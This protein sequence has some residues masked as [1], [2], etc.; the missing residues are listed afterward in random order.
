[1]ARFPDVWMS[2][3]YA[4]SDIVD[5]I[6]SYTT[7]TERGGNYWGLCPFHNEKLPS[8]SVN[9]EKQ[10]Y[11]CFGCK[12]GGNVTNFI[13]QTENLS[14]GEAVEFLARRAG[15][16]MP[17]MVD[18]MRFAQIK[19]KKQTIAQMNKK[20]AQFYRDALYSPKGTEALKYLK[21]RGIGE[22][23]IKLFGL[24]YAPDEWDSV[25][26]LLG[27]E[28]FSQSLI[29]ESGLVTVKDNKQYD[30]FRGR[31]MFPIINA[32]GDVIA[33]GGRVLGEAVPKYLNTK[34]TALFNKRFNL[35]G[36]NIL[37]K[38][39]SAR[40]AVIVEG[41]MDVVSMFAHGVKAVVASLGTALTKQQA[42]LLKRYV[43]DCYIAYD[44]DE[45]GEAATKKAI[46]ILET[47]GLSVRV[48]RFEPGQDPDDF[49]K[50]HGLSGFAEKVKA[51]PGSV[52]YKLN[53][54][55]AEHDLST[56][57]GKEA[58]AIEA[59]NILSAIESPITRE[60][61]A[62]QV[63]K[64]TGYSQT[65]VIG[66]MQKKS[67]NKNISTSNRYNNT[68]KGDNTDAQTA[69][70][71]Y[72]MANTRYFEKASEDLTAE[73]F[74]T[75]PHKNIFSALCECAK[76]GIQ[77]TYAEII[78]ELEAQEDRNEAAYLAGIEVFA[79]DPS[80]YLE[81]CA[82]RIRVNKRKAERAELFAKLRGAS[83]D[84]KR[85]LLADIGRIDK[86][87]SEARLNE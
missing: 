2:D 38:Q 31:I 21:N 15:L 70:L 83:G 59:S 9:R 25:A 53:C 66:Q 85:K 49:I 16:P 86:E 6:S 68:L 65:S 67:V 12:Q 63:S 61:Y 17:Q 33:F 40:S 73:D 11:Y 74:L 37:R 44:G 23:A 87:L 41:Y 28:G 8:F 72:A 69:F 45:A 4:K 47:Q 35:Y 36:I 32:I 55:E 18:D 80:A 24:G 19:Q 20:A 76:R 29:N 81:D 82:K 46:D 62:E 14:F 48:I 52:G 51:A 39:R 58:F 54:A 84:E 42:L 56:E 78:S 71:S 30:M 10:F 1:M 79:D 34:E 50:K 60:R 27:K 13:M 3:L 7:L 5:V 43:S 64:K 75:Q 22:D 26:A 57:D 77:P